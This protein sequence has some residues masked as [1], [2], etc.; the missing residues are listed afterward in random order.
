[1]KY[2]FKITRIPGKES[3]H[4]YFKRILPKLMKEYDISCDIADRLVRDT[5][6]KDINKIMKDIESGKRRLMP[7]QTKLIDE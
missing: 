5:L 4:W 7:I 3:Y 6:M 2:M 1:M